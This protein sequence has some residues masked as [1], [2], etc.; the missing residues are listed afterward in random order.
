VTGIDRWEGSPAALPAGVTF[1]IERVGHGTTPDRSWRTRYN[2][3]KAAGLAVGFYYVP[4][5]TDVKG[6]AEFF[7]E[8]VGNI[9]HEMGTWLDYAAGDLGGLT[10]SVG[11]V[12]EFRGVFDCGLYTN[13][14]YLMGPL[15]AYQRF[16]R[17]W[18]AGSAPPARWLMRQTGGLN[19][20]D[21]IDVAA[22]LGAGVRPGWTGFTWPNA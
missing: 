9:A 7:A 14:A 19:S 18:F 6:Q 5:S 15:A 22:D 4:E 3:D 12:D 11:F 16:E 10:P 13:G 2:Q 1:A 17:L 21:D 20:G 8:Q